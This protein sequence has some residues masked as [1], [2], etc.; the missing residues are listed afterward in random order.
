MLV[1]VGQ[2]IRLRREEVGLSRSSFAK[3]AGIGSLTTVQNAEVG[4]FEVSPLNQP[5]FEKGLD[6]APGAIR[7]AM[8][9]VGE[10]D[11]AEL[12]MAMM[13]GERVRPAS[14]SLQGVSF[15]DLLAEVARRYKIAEARGRVLPA[16]GWHDLAASDD[17]SRREDGG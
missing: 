11:P 14:D 17:M 7:R 12:S 5:K 15:D 16:Q 3:A 8:D 4:A 1:R 9:R 13:D 10:L 2:L 6:W